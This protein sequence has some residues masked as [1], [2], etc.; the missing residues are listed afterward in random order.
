MH[1]LIL[2]CV[3]LLAFRLCDHVVGGTALAITLG[4]FTT[5]A[6]DQGIGLSVLLS[7]VVSVSPGQSGVSAARETGCAAE[8][9]E[10]RCVA[11]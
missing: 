2:L 10:S 4:D 9:T 3:V 6:I 5:E 11:G 8:G 1:G 7:C